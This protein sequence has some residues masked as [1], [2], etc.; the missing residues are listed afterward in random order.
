MK[1]N[2]A[3]VEKLRCVALGID[4]TDANDPSCLAVRINAKR[5]RIQ[6]HST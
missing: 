6:A 2:V 1:L 5:P 4:E 3:C